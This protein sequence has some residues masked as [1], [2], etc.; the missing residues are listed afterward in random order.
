VRQVGQL[1]RNINMFDVLL[2][3]CCNNKRFLYPEAGWRQI[4]PQR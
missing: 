2:I 3:G 4:T 1:P